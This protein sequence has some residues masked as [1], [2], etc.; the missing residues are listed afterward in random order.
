MRLLSW[1]KRIYKK[2]VEQY[3]EPREIATGAAVG[4]F[5]G[6]FPTFGFGGLLA[7]ALSWV[8]KYNRASAI[9]AS[10]IMNPIT[11]PFFWFISLFIGVMIWGED[12]NFYTNIYKNEGIVQLVKEGAVVY[13]TGNIIVSILCSVVV[14]LLV[15][16]EARRAK[17][18]RDKK[19]TKDIEIGSSYNSI[20]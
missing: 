9:L 1:I 17:Q 15:Y 6:I 16:F 4:V 2:I 19:R 3:A 8:F 14:W 10:A 11:S 7:L 18:R 5:I 13:F 12:V 20:L